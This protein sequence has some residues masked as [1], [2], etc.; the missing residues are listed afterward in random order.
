[1]AINRLD[2][3]EEF[4]LKLVMVMFVLDKLMEVLMQWP[5]AYA[6]DRGIPIQAPHR[7]FASRG[8]LTQRVTRAIR[9]L[10]PVASCNPAMKVRWIAMTGPATGGG[11]EGSKLRH[12]GSG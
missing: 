8:D 1:M 5:F 3:S 6:G 12:E 9:S 11:G 4:M 7:R 10:N 2:P